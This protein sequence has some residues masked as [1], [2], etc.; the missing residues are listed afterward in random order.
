MRMTTMRLGPLRPASGLHG[1][2][3]QSYT[4]SADECYA[5]SEGWAP[6]AAAEW[7]SNNGADNRQCALLHYDV[8]APTDC[9]AGTTSRVGTGTVPAQGYAGNGDP[10]NVCWQP[11]VYYFG[12][13]EGNGHDGSPWGLAECEL[14]PKAL[15]RPVFYFFI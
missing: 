1:G 5:K 11:Q 14:F 9:P 7:R 2:W 13:T 4:D 15:V 10:Q 8:A 3:C 6:F 12:P